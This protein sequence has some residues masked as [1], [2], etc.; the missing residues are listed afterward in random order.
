MCELTCNP[1]RA[2][3]K[4]RLPEN[5]IFLDLYV[6][7]RHYPFFK[8]SWC[9][10]QRLL[11]RMQCVSEALLARERK[12]R[13]SDAELFPFLL[14]AGAWKALRRRAVTLR[15]LAATFIG[16]RSPTTCCSSACC[17]WK[18]ACALLRTSALPSSP[19]YLGL[20]KSCSGCASAFS[21][22]SLRPSCF[23]GGV[24]AEGHV[25]L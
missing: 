1:A 5:K 23:S 14:A 20:N 15:L 4:R 16:C 17:T 2:K 8:G 13:Q 3:Q 19:A 9:F 25:E 24:C 12:H 22:F 6:G 7:I 10:P 18:S 11:G 21:D